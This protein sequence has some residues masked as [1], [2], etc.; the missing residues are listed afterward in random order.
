MKKEIEIYMCD[1]DEA[2]IRAVTPLISNLIGEN[3]RIKITEF[4]DGDSLI[5]KCKT[6]IPDVVFLDIDMPGMNGF[7]IADKLHANN[8]DMCII[9]LTSY[10]DMVYRS[11]SYQPFWFVRKS[12][13]QDL[14]LVL[15]Q[16]LTK[17]DSM[18]EKICGIVELCI[19]SKIYEINI[20]TITSIYSHKHYII[21]EENYKEVLKIRGKISDIEA[22]ISKMYFVSVQKG[23]LVNLRFVKKITSRHVIFKNGFQINISRSYIDLVK[24]EYQRYMRSK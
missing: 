16:L 12:H 3:R 20:N 7:E 18:Y 14:N 2:F 23:I 13:L 22:Q 10:D 24:S 17:I 4:L 21:L 15:S 5:K 1:D 6:N 11:W 19:D 8:M 9:F